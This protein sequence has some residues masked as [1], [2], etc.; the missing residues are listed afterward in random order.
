[1]NVF[2]CEKSSRVANPW[3]LLNFEGE[4]L[5]L[6]FGDRIL[7]RVRRPLTNRGRRMGLGVFRRPRYLAKTPSKTTPAD[8]DANTIYLKQK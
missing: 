8:S 4:L 5:E 6:P 1:M 3:K 7:F 2:C